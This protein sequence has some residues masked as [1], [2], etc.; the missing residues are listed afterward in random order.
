[1]QYLKEMNA[2][3]CTCISKTYQNVQLLIPTSIVLN[4]LYRWHYSLSS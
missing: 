2:D 3:T 4:V 1:M